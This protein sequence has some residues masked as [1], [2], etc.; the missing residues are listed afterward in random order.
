MTSEDYLALFFSL[1]VMQ[2][3]I[4]IVAVSGLW[5]SISRKA[6]FPRVSKW[7]SWGF[8]LL[9]AHSLTSITLQLVMIRIRTEMAGPDLAAAFFWPSLLGV[10]AYP[11]FIAGFVMLARAIFLD[12][13]INRHPIDPSV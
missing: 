5:L 6:H 10:A 7:A 1:F 2:I 8:S 13:D 12:R 4:L 3:P 9:I 11:L